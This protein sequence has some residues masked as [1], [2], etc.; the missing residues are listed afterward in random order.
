MSHASRPILGVQAC[1]ASALDMQLASQYL[2]CAKLWETTSRFTGSARSLELLFLR[3]HN[4]ASAV[5]L[6]VLHAP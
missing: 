5:L 4:V 2:Q 6:P 1:M 3:K